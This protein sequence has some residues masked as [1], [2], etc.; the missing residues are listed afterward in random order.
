[1]QKIQ[2][3]CDPCHEEDG[4]EQPAAHHGVQ[5][6][7][8]TNV[9][10]A[11]MCDRHKEWL[12]NQMD[13]YFRAGRR[14]D[15]V[16][17]PKAVPKGKGGPKPTPAGDFHCPVK[18]C[19]RSFASGQ[20]V[21]MHLTRVHLVPGIASH[22][23]EAHDAAIRAAS[24]GDVAPSTIGNTHVRRDVPAAVPAKVS[25]RAGMTE[26]QRERERERDRA[27]KARKRQELA[28]AN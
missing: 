28:K 20:G 24:G 11:D 16:V 18:D 3:L 4:V 19:T 26:D 22:G 5:F 1:M 9:M 27:R 25:L 14:P 7:L 6:S 13:L 12:A 17:T 2:H 21:S 8:G 23:Q 15:A 10:V